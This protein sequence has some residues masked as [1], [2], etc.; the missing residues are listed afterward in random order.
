MLECYIQ[1]SRTIRML[2]RRVRDLNEER[3][4]DK[5]SDGVGIISS[6]ILMDAREL[7]RLWPDGLT[8][9]P[10]EALRGAVAA[11]GDDDVRAMIEDIV[12]SI[13]DSIDDHFGRQPAGDIRTEVL[14]LMHPVI[15]ASSY[16]QFRTGLYRDAV[17]N[18]ILAV[19][20]LIRRRTGLDLDGAHL[21]ARAFAIDKP[22]LSV[23]ALDTES[24]QNDQKGFIQLL[25]GAYLG[26][27]NPKAHSLLSELTECSAAQYLVFASIL[28]R[29]IAEAR[30][31]ELPMDSGGSSTSN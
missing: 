1:L 2:A 17:L 30:A 27:R 9:A 31:H 11:C 24:G 25:Q 13:E 29:R 14:D 18:A 23:A 4:Y 16:Q 20:D 7:E 22:L 10:I 21:A 3:F 5:E 6:Y 19:S 28:A 26:I 12:P 15:I 8:T